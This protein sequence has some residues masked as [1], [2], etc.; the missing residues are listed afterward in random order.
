MK[1]FGRYV[2]VGTI[3]FAIGLVANFPYDRIQDSIKE[4]QALKDVKPQPGPQAIA[5]RRP[6]G[7]QWASAPK[8]S[9]EPQPVNRDLSFHGSNARQ[10]PVVLEFT[11]NFINDA[12]CTSLRPE[13]VNGLPVR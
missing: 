13:P 4:V 11:T 7:C 12:S 8:H 2:F 1:R 5:P 3:V 10:G 9:I 6:G